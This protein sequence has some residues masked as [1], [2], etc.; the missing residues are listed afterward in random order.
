MKYFF[1]IFAEFMILV[2]SG[3]KDM[4]FLPNLPLGEF[5][6]NVIA[7]QQCHVNHNSSLQFN[8]FLSKTSRTTTELRGNI[9]IF[10]RPFDD[11]LL[12]RGT[13]A[14]RDKIGTWQN[15]AYVYNSPKAYSS[16]KK[17]LGAEFP[18]FMNSFG[19]ND[20]IQNEMPP[21]IYIFKGYNISNYPVNTNFPKQLFYGTYI[22]KVMYLE[23]KSRRSWVL[24][25]YHRS[26]TS[27]G[28]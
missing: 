14:I 12:F 17:L 15:N 7:T 8:F 19:A 13:M 10:N 25:I 16:L 27:L 3:G 4:K 1:I 5:R 9:S 6:V 24:F 26:K 11:S 2:D 23:K 21:G 28:N 18:I 20:T 22:F